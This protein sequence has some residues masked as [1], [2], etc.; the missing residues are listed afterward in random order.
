ME[1]QGQFD[2]VDCR[3]LKDLGFKPMKMLY[4]KL[5]IMLRD[6]LGYKSRIQ[7]KR[8]RIAPTMTSKE[9]HKEGGPLGR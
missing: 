8:G 6:C 3:Y 4:G 2:Y 5:G 1:V 7:E 9:G